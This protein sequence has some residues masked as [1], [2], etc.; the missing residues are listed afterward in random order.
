MTAQ[1]H[2]PITLTTL[3]AIASALG[4][5]GCPGPASPPP[6][7]APGPVATASG[8]PGACTA[9]AQIEI[10]SITVAGQNLTV[11][12]EPDPRPISKNGDGV[13]WKLKNTGQQN[14]QFSGAG[15][16]FAANSPGGPASA[17]QSSST[18]EIVW[19][20]G[21]TTG[22]LSWK[23]SALITDGTNKWTCD[24]TIVNNESVM[25]VGGASSPGPAAS[26]VATNPPITCLRQ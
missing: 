19:C 18:T 4:L 21:A 24:P 6:P 17:P 3:G 10:K 7:A 11:V 20:F 26:A 5:T 22:D 8:P 1:R 9:N 15:I 16:V 23:Y 2:A 12:L 14:Y 13:R 25:R